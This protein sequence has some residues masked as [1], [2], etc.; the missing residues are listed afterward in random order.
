MSEV[1]SSITLKDACADLEALMG[2]LKDGDRK[3]A[4]SL[5]NGV[6]GFKKRGGL[7]DKQRP[8]I[9]RLLEMAMGGRDNSLIDVGNVVG[10]V[11]LVNKAKGV[12]KYPKIVFDAGFGKVKIWVQGDKAKFPGAIG[13]TVNGM[14]FGRIHQDGQFQASGT[15][16]TSTMKDEFLDLLMAFAADPAG[17]GAKYGKLS[18][19]CCF[20][21]KFLDDPKSLGVGYGPVCAKNYGLP[22]GDAKVSMATVTGA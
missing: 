9:F 21:Q 15:Y 3:F 7:T 22:W 19:R 18:G 1:N 16:D 4:D 11:A 13:L 17:V 20:C 14:W 12:I 6:Y 5:I 2:N 10:I 8:H